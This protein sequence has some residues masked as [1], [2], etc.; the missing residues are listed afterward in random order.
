MNC[1][2]AFKIQNDNFL[3]D[4]I[5]NPAKTETI[6]LRSIDSIFKNVEIANYIL[7]NNYNRKNHFIICHLIMFLIYTNIG[8][9]LI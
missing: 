8:S 2:D 3:L 1:G 5:I 7:N 6:S 4:F 9:R